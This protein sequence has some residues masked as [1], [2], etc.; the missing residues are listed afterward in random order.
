MSFARTSRL[1]ALSFCLPIMLF[2]L[3]SLCVYGQEHG[4]QD[5]HDAAAPTK[6]PPNP[7]EAKSD[8]LP[9][10]P[11]DASAEQT[12]TV[13]GKTLRY[14][15]T[16]GVIPVYNRTDASKPEVKTGEVVVTSY[17][18]IGIKDSPTDR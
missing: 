3:V 1:F 10:L 16:V 6:E 7:A 14:T 12:L 13:N 2:G 15:A 4:E 9:P 17:T 8:P 5:H 11:P 18:L